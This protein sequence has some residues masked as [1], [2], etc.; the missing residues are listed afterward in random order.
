[1]KQDA[2]TRSYSSLLPGLTTDDGSTPQ[3]LQ[4]ALL[5]LYVDNHRLDRLLV[6]LLSLTAGVLVSFWVPL[7][8]AAAWVLICV[9]LTY[10]CLFCYERFSAEA[11]VLSVDYWQRRIGLCHGVLVLHWSMLGLW[12][13]QPG[14]LTNHLSILVILVGVIATTTAMSAPSLRLYLQDMATPCFVLIVRPLFE[15]EAVYTLIAGMATCFCLLM[16]HVGTQIHANLVNMVKLQLEKNLLILKLE[17]MAT[18]DGLTGVYNR[19]YFMLAAEEELR[20]C[21]R[22][23]H[24]TTLLMVD[25]DHFKSVNDRYGHAMGD[26]VLKKL[27]EVLCGELRRSDIVGRVGGEEFALLLPETNRAMAL[28][29]AERIRQRVKQAE[30]KHGND[31]LQVTLSI[32]VCESS[33]RETRLE[34]MLDTADKRLYQAK[35]NGRDQVVCE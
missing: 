4:L 19:R 2:S 16:G 12:A 14:D 26:L 17:N 23:N 7:W 29:I 25:V 33:A 30:F 8:L 24:D 21:H 27:A 10:A 15:G 20:R 35:H 5:R 18:T 34:T 6:P 13:W 1:M 9:G 31:R 28:L 22:Y 32:G 3:T 11:D